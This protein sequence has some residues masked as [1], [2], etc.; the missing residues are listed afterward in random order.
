MTGEEWFIAAVN[1]CIIG[2]VTI[3]LG[4]IVLGIF[5]LW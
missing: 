2:T 3:L 5:G 1:L 4:R